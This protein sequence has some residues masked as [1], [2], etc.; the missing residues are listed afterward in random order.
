MRRV[1]W[2]IVPVVASC[3]A[4][5][6]SAALAAAQTSGAGQKPIAT[7]VGIDANTIN[8]EVVAAVDVPGSAGLFQGSVNGVKAWAQYENDHGGLAHRKITVS[9]VDSKLG[10]ENAANA[11]IQ[12]C[13][14]SFALIG[15]S[16]ILAQNFSDLLTCKDKT[17]AAT[18][19]PDFPVVVTEVAQQCSP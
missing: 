3:L 11:F 9:F 16:V 13:D 2:F 19:L 18:G 10:S 5:A 8:I 4:V 7:D 14:S 6:T 15:T 17:G 12:G 1:R